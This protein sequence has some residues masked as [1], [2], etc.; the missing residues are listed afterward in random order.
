M[1]R[2]PLLVAAALAALQGCAR[3]RAAGPDPDAIPVVPMD[4]GHAVVRVLEVRSFTLR[5]GA[6]TY[7][8]QAGAPSLRSGQLVALRAEPA[9][10][11][12]RQVKSPVLYAGPVPV[13]VVERDAASGCVV[14]V[15]PASVDARKEPFY[16]GSYE[17]PERVDAV[18]GRAER[19]AA[20]A[21]G[22]RPRPPAESA[23][24]ST[25][26]VEL[27][28]PTALSSSLHAAL[29]GCRRATP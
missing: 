1:T 8:F 28:D 17:L 16:F 18:R 24:W 10:L 26:S 6:L 15:I 13:Q 2:R 11:Q 21:A 4:D 9:F 5:E 23:S 22:L 12:L 7:D 19:D 27:R 20:L 29:E 3:A 14:G 25:G